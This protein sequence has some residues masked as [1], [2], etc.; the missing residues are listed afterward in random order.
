MD[1][2]VLSRTPTCA[3]RVRLQRSP[4]TR[5]AAFAW[6]CSPVARPARVRAGRA[7]A[8]R[9][10]FAPRAGNNLP[11]GDFIVVLHKNLCV[12]ILLLHIVDARARNGQR[13]HNCSRRR[14][15][16]LNFA[17][18]HS[19]N[20][21][22]AP[23]NRIE[24]LNIRDCIL[25][26]QR[27]G[28]LVPHFY[29]RIRP[30]KL[31]QARCARNCLDLRRIGGSAHRGDQGPADLILDQN[32]PRAVSNC[33]LVCAGDIGYHLHGTAVTAGCGQRGHRIGGPVLR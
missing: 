14:V 28:R 30:R 25:A 17:V 7:Q 6:I 9:Y 29:E 23:V 21:N 20:Y 32:L 19:D 2:V 4:G 31:N 8:N 1:S 10:A 11:L 16:K 22:V 18:R 15:L 3:G 12:C 27:C 5:W 24:A 26:Y 13:E 33:H